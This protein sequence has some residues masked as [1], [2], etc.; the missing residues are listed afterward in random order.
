LRPGI[1]IGLDKAGFELH[2]VFISKF[3]WFLWI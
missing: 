2:T 1:G 3:K